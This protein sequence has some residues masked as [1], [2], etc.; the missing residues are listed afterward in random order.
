VTEKLFDLNIE[1]ML[2]N[3]EVHHALREVIANALDERVLSD[4]EPIE[5]FADDEGR[6]HVRDYGRGLEIAD[7]TLSED[8]EKLNASSGVIGS[9]GV[10]LKD[11]LATFHRRGVDVEIR[12]SWGTYWLDTAEK[13]N[14]DEIETLHV[15]YDDAP[16]DIQGTD[17][18]LRGVTRQDVDLAKSLFMAFAGEN[19]I[20]TTPYGQILRRHPQGARVYIQ[21]VLANEEPNFLFSYNITDLT[22]G[23]KKR[24]NRERFNVG[25][26]VYAPRIRS[27][28]KEAESPV[29]HERLVE[30]VRDQSAGPTYDEMGWIEISQM[31]LNLM[32]KQRKVVYFTEDEIESRPDV[33]SSVLSEGYE[34]VT[35]TEQ[36]KERLERQEMQT[37]AR[38]QASEPSAS[39]E[40]RTV[41]R[42][43]EEFRKSFEY[44]F[45]GPVSLD[46]AERAVYEKTR[47]IVAVVG[48]DP[49]SAPEVRI[50][51]TL[52]FSRQRAGGTWDP[53]LQAV[54]VERGKLA[55]LPEYAATV[56]HEL[57]RATAQVA[58]LTPEFERVLTRY[59]G[60]AVAAAV[61][62][63]DVSSSE[64]PDEPPF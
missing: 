17:F 57:V 7:F 20:E 38:G 29:V 49:E 16:T 35:I 15:R 33:F 45:V 64:S 9:F 23:M 13:H 10:G 34:P 50:S 14:F 52:P 47:E 4:S 3:W 62:E 32:P 39:S 31:A 61:G 5:I 2:E 22:P 6:W 11:A 63:G 60:Q 59:L 18:M 53:S 37:P 48:L 25:R 41:V 24:L 36:Q 12:S 27:I 1:E 28:L 44:Q 19:V 40:V 21:G 46:P 51:E 26:T 43:V 30:A 56:L 8:P 54:I 55:S 42:Y 58:Y